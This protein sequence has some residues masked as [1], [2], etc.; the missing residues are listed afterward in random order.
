MLNQTHPP[1]KFDATWLTTSLERIY[2]PDSKEPGKFGHGKEIICLFKLLGTTKYV[3]YHVG[4]KLQQ[5]MTLK[6]GPL[7]SKKCHIHHL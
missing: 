5:R 2:R 4:K 1:I 6:G 3:G 7:I